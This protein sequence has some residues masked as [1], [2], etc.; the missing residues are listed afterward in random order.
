MI[1]DNKVLNN[2][3]KMKQIVSNN[4]QLVLITIY[5]HYHRHQF[6]RIQ[7][8]RHKTQHK[9]VRVNSISVNHCLSMEIVAQITVTCIPNRSRIKYLC[10]GGSEETIINET[11]FTK[12]RLDEP[13]TKPTLVHLFSLLQK[14]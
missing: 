5:Q 2:I 8:P 12:I 13:N 7:V 1:Y 14:K 6:I 10:D 9:P 11:V 3:A 4:K